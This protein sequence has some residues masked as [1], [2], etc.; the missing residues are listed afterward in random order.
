MRGLGKGV[1]GKPYPRLCNA[2][3]PRLET[4]DLPVTGGKTLQLAP[5]PPFIYIEFRIPLNVTSVDTRQTDAKVFTAT[6]ILLSNSAIYLT[7]ICAV[8][9]FSDFHIVMTGILG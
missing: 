7:L 1:S 5:G 9:M 6:L 4:R 8:K 3:R 2:R